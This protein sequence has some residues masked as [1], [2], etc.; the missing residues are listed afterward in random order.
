MQLWNQ[1]DLD[2]MRGIQN[3]NLRDTCTVRRPTTTP[4]GRGG[5]TTTWTT[6]L[7]NVPCRVWISSGPNG[8]SEESRFYADQEMNI[9]DSFLI[10]AWDSDVRVEDEVVYNIPAEQQHAGGPTTR[11]YKVVGTNAPDTIITALRARIEAIRA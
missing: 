10:M 6:V 8:T 2:Y 9:T 11:T 3:D 4:N 1:A 7:E 5:F